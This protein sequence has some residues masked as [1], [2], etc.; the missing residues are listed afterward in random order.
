[1]AYVCANS[2][3][4]C[5]ALTDFHMPKMSNEEFIYYSFVKSH[6]SGTFKR[7]A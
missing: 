4:Y 2:I 1:M 5:K 6:V 7:T 3:F